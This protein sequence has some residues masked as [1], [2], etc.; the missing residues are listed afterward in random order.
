MRRYCIQTGL[1]VV[2]TSASR[3]WLKFTNEGN[4]MVNGKLKCKSGKSFD[5][6]SEFKLGDDENAPIE[7]KYL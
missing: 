2:S 7:L 3:T 4:G 1:R 5:I 6:R